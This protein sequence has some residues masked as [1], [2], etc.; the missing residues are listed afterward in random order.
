MTG[1]LDVASQADELLRGVN[2]W[3]SARRER[4]EGPTFKKVSP[5]SLPR[6]GDRRRRGT[7]KPAESSGARTTSEVNSPN[8]VAFYRT[9]SA[10]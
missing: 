7:T 5:P 3:T 8:A 10:G 2:G 1:A 4:V 6:R 9:H